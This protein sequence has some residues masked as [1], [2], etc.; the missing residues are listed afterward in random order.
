VC[1]LLPLASPIATVIAA[2]AASY[3]A[4]RFGKGQ[5]GIAEEQKRIAQQQAHL[6]TVRLKHDLFDRRYEI[7]EVVFFF[8]IEIFQ[9]SNLSQEA[10]S[11]FV[12]GTQKAVFVF[13]Q[14]TVDY[15]E[16]LRKRAIYLQEAASFLGDQRNPIGEERTRAASR[17]AE[18]FTWFTEQLPVLVERMKPFMALDE[19]TASRAYAPVQPAA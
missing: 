15:F 5:L 8:L 10:M 3:I 14:A 1:N 7:Y 2:G 17:R 9:S 16:E 6:A 4:Y 11:K 19:N 13:D 12:R 18:L